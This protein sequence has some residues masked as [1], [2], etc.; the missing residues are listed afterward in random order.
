MT[1]RYRRCGVVAENSLRT[2]AGIAH[3]TTDDTT[4][5]S[6]AKGAIMNRHTPILATILI[7]GL[8]GLAACGGDDDDTGAPKNWKP[9]V[10]VLSDGGTEAAVGAVLGTAGMDTVMGPLWYEYEG[11][12][13]YLYD[14]VVLLTGEDY[15]HQMTDTAMAR[16]T[17]YVAGGGGL[18][19]TEW[20]AYYA[21][22]NAALTG[23]L[24]IL[25]SED[26]DYEAETLRPVSG[27]PLV[28]GL[29][30]AIATGPDWTW[31]TLIPDTT[32][33]KQARVAVNGDLGGPAVVTGA[34]GNGRTVAWGMAG[35]Y[36]GDDI[37]TPDVEK[38]LVRIVS[39]A[40]G[41]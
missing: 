14:A 5:P 23:I 13:L 35:V 25:E 29:P 8:L 31:I 39:W 18:V 24:P 22:R 40:A 10:L 7:L 37:W 28:R 26:Y 6:P 4:H 36:E 32:A 21:S 19:T 12:D 17:Q 41:N 30:D 3:V 16:L 9:L 15:Y 1:T 33:A 2:G 11:E 38:L 20:L 27:H 34:H